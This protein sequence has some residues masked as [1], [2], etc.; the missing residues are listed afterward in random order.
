MTHE[1]FHI[2]LDEDLTN[3]MTVN[4]NLSQE[5]IVTNTDKVTILLNDHHKIVKK[6]TEWLN[7]LGIFISVLTALLTSKFD[8]PKFGVS[9]ELWK[10]L[11][12]IACLISF[13]WSVY[14]I[15]IAICY[16]NRGTVGEF[17]KKLKNESTNQV[18]AN[19][20]QTT[21]TQ[22]TPVIEIISATYL[23]PGDQ[24]GITNEIKSLVSKGILTGKVDPGVL[25]IDD[26]KYG[27][28]KTLKIHYRINGQEKDLT[29]K[30]GETFTIE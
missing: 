5:I 26:P 15:V 16:R 7:P 27:T 24:K 18:S 1:N 10:S 30:D 22:T 9:P 25:G 8:E 2:K 21:S 12:I 13:I 3:Q 17:I 19:S 23:W 14:L 11:F 6:K 4:K 29:A 20:S 28:E